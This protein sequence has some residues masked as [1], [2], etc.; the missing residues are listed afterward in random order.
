MGNGQRKLKKGNDILR[1]VSMLGVSVGFIAVVYKWPGYLWIL[2]ISLV[3]FFFS[4]FFRFY[5]KDW[6]FDLKRR[7][8]IFHLLAGISL[9]LSSVFGSVGLALFALI[10][11]AVALASRMKEPRQT[12]TPSLDK[13]IKEIGQDQT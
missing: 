7:S 3:L 4:Y 5:L 11:F 1:L 12:A 2:L 13:K 6:G 10:C 8:G 9:L